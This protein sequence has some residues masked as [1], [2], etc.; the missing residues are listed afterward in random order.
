[1]NS[2]EPIRY[3]LLQERWIPCER[4]DGSR[5]LVGIEEAIVESHTFAALNDESPLVTAM[6]HRLLLAILQRVFLPRRM[7]DWLALWEA[8]SFDAGKVREYLTRWKDRF[9]LFHPDRP[10]LQVPNLR[11]M[12]RNERGKDPESTEA[13]RLAMESSAHSNATHLF[14]PPPHDPRLSPSSAALALLGFLAFTPG[15]RIQNETDSWDAANI[16]GGAVVVVHGETLRGTLTMNL[17]W[18]RDRSATDLPPWERSESA[19]RRTRPPFG[20]IDQLVWQSRRVQLLPERDRDGAVFVRDVLTAAGEQFDVEHPD[21][22]FAYSVRDP[23]RPPMATRIERDRSAWRDSAALFFT[24]SGAGDFRPPRACEQLAELVR[25]GAVPRT[26]RL[27]VELFGL[28]S[29]KASIRLWRSDRMPLHPSLL[30]DGQRFSI[31]RSALQR[32]EHLWFELNTQVLRVLAENA[33]A[34]S[35]R[36]THADDVGN[37]RAALGAMPAYWA[38][39]GH[40]FP[41]WLDLLGSANDLDAVATNWMHALRATALRV[42]RDAELRLGTGARALQAAAKADRTLW[43]VLRDVLGDE[44]VVA[45]GTT[46]RTATTDAKTTQGAPA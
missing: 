45:T 25:S 8:P 43:R 3:D 12:L 22:M 7:D 11:E 40:A 36:D 6:L 16:R 14:E 31:L 46:T 42:V 26:A 17:F 2:S 20:F 44:L 28:A 10:F 37:L 18:Q 27:R 15:G 32:A 5:T 29:N 1:M 13:W 39:L 23:K 24:A 33:L 4:P 30:V 38:A 35:Q 19:Q 21:P 9:D 41:P 34:P